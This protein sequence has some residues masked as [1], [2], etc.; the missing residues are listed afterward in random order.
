MSVI[1]FRTHAQVLN[2]MK[3]NRTT[4]YHQDEGCGCCWQSTSLEYDGARVTIHTSGESQGSVH[5]DVELI[6]ILRKRR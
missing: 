6:G 5:Y 4:N 1:V 2:Y 3:R